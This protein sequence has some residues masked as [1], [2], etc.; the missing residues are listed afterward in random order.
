MRII[1]SLGSNI[2]PRKETLSR[3]LEALSSFP[4]TRLVRKS[5]VVE[6]D[7]IDVP[8]Q[9]AALKFLN[10]LVEFESALACEE[11]SRRM[12]ALEADLGRVRTVRNGPRTIDI[13]MISCGGET[14][15]SAELT[16]P[17]PRARERA[18]VMEPL[19]DFQFAAVKDLYD[20]YVAKYRSGDG[21]LPE[22]MQLKYTHTMMVTDNARQIAAGENFKRDERFAAV[23]ASLL[24]DTGR[25]EQ[26]RRF[27]TFKD[28][29][30]VNHAVFSHD[31][32]KSNGWLDQVL[33]PP[34][35]GRE[36][37]RPILDAVLFHNRREVPVDMDPLTAAAA[38]TVR[39]A[40]KLDIFRVLEDLVAHTDWRHDA[41]PF[42]NL[43]VGR[44]PS[45]DVVAAIRD[46][47]PVD[48]QQIRSLA[49]FVLIQVGWMISDLHFA[50]SRR[51]CRER[52]HLAF[53]RRF[54]A[55]I[56][57]GKAAEEL[58]DLAEAT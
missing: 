18:F 49:D 30:S 3:A 9:F 32:V 54:L 11:F 16:L 56:G 29:D 28:S 52:G 22:M 40:D 27:N 34:P 20:E 23:T 36:L 37:I 1:V 4:S 15:E 12:H 38:F 14:R 47:R 55:E 6:T 25:Y 50:V 43:E 58:C 19:R 33:S 42:W 51:L 35:L 31:I 8:E 17:H 2:E 5:E 24:H 53:R 26:L 44:P 45:D 48:Y 46:H 7:P 57:G 21:R 13:D 41:R 10:Q 39:D